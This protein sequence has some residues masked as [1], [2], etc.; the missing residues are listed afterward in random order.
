MTEKDVPT[1]GEIL[2]ATQYIEG[3]E[4]TAIATSEVALTVTTL[5]PEALDQYIVG[6]STPQVAEFAIRVA[7]VAKIAYK[8]K[9][10]ANLRLVELEQTGKFFVDPADGT[11]YQFTGGRHRE[12]K[13]LDGFVSDLAA[14]GIDARPLL[15]WLS[16]G[17]FKVGETIKGDERI[18]AAVNEWAVWTDDPLALVE[19]D[20]KTLRPVKRY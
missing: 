2:S 5:T 15:P 11:P 19:L 4:Q 9:Q 6:L 13:N 17:A 10:L 1:Y 12:I 18:K 20:R 7:A 3:K 8:A 14:Q 16:S